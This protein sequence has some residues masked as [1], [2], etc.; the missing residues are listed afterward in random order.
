VKYKLLAIFAL[1]M[2]M[3]L[4]FIVPNVHAYPVGDINEDHVVNILDVVLAGSQY[5][6]KP[7]DPGYNSTIVSRADLAPPYNGIIDIIDMVTIIM[8]Y[9]QHD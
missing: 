9:G 7:T 1:I 2:T 6:R 3:S 5:M 4:L 8:H